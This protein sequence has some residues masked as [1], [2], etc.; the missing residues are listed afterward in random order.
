MELSEVRETASDL[1]EMLLLCSHAAEETLPSPQTFKRRSQPPRANI[2]EENPTSLMTSSPEEVPVSAPLRPPRD[3]Q[4]E[5]PTSFMT[6]S[7]EE[8]PSSAPLRPPRDL[9]DRTRGTGSSSTVSDVFAGTGTTQ[10]RTRQ[11]ERVAGRPRK[12]LGSEDGPESVD[13]PPGPPAP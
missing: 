13:D 5:N 2:Q 9:K 12:F 10:T 6:S 4:E 3:L 1:R 7:P 8:V 11:N